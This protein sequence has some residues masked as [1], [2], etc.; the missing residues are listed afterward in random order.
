M[1]KC[2]ARPVFGDGS[3]IFSTVGWMEGVTRYRAQRSWIASGTV[4]HVKAA[5]MAGASRSW[6][7]HLLADEGV[8]LRMQM[9]SKTWFFVWAGLFTPNAVVP[10]VGDQRNPRSAI[11]EIRG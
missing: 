10:I 6:S 11:T 7:T 5:L 9:G 2:D 4:E 8:R 1:P 3:W